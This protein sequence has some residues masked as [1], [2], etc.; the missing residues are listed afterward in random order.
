MKHICPNCGFEYEGDLD[1][2]PNCGFD[3]N[4]VLNDQTEKVDEKNT[5]EDPSTKIND[6][7]QW[8]VFHEMPIEDVADILDEDLNDPFRDEP[9]LVDEVKSDEP[10]LEAAVPNDTDKKEEATKADEPTEE[11]VE[12]AASEPEEKTPLADGDEDE[13][14]STNWLLAQYIKEHRHGDEEDDESPQEA[15]QV[16]ATEESETADVPQTPV[17]ETD[18]TEKSEDESQTKSPIIDVIPV[19]PV[20]TEKESIKVEEPVAFD[21]VPFAEEEEAAAEASQNTGTQPESKTSSTQ[22]TTSHRQNP[23]QRKWLIVGAAAV[24]LFGAGGFAYHHYTTQQ[25]AEAQAIAKAMS[26]LQEEMDAFYLDDAHTYVSADKVDDNLS[27]IEDHIREHR[28]QEG[29]D[30]L[31]ADFATLEEKVTAI[32]AINALFTAPVINGDALADAPLLAANSPITLETQTGDDDLS[33]LINQAIAEASSQ[34]DALQAAEEAVAVVYSNGAVVDGV[35][36]DQYNTASEAVAAVAN[37]ELTTDLSNQLAQVEAA[38]TT[39]EAEA[40]QAA[41]AGNTGSGSGAG[42]NAASDGGTSNGSGGTTGGDANTSGGSSAGSSGSSSNYSVGEGGAL[43]GFVMNTNQQP[44]VESNAADIADTGNPAWTWESGVQ[45]RVVATCIERG[46]INSSNYV[47][48]RALI[49]DGAGFYN[50]Y[51]IESDGS[52]TYLVTI[53][54]KTGWFKGN[55]PGGPATRVN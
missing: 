45:E 31:V 34:Y 32:R 27:V 6:D 9:L 50:L 13:V 8:S 21:P 17:E 47:I 52:K 3:L 11:E 5:D 36:R 4:T 39:Q 37:Q 26:D 7:I 46:Y 29:Y 24:V 25:A 19:V 33:R 23:K 54:C 14:G 1:K 43:N 28:G 53:N 20:P 30:A 18:S 2:C 38:L 48:E 10:T 42:S 16:E 41:N 12:A 51:R 44:I 40:E 22:A 55:G 15:S 35:T 49:V